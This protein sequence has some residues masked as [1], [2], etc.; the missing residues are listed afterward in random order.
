MQILGSFPYYPAVVEQY[1]PYLS[2]GTKPPTK[3]V[4]ERNDVVFLHK[5]LSY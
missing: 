1:L 4:Q 3:K 2:Y 5:N